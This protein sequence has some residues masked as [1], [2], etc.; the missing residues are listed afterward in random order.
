MRVSLPITIGM[1]AVLISAACGGGPPPE[2]VMPAV[3]SAAIRDSIARAQAAA[4]ERARQDSIRRAQEEAERLRRLE[5]Q[6]RREA[7]QRETA[8][9]RRMLEEMINFDYD[10]SNIRS[11]NDAQR[12]EQKLAI[13]QANPSLRI[14]VVGHC[15]ERGTDEYNMALGNRRAIAA[16]RFLTDRGISESRITVRSRGEEEPIAM[17]SNEAAWAQNRRAEFQITGGGNVLR[18]PGM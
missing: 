14:Q 4:A 9:V 11:G 15:D 2:P 3:D 13:L 1:T 6:R 16:R 5:E 12:L 10:R 18:R 8:E 7:E 17:G